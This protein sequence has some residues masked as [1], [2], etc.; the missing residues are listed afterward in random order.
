M[1]G[2]FVRYYVHTYLC[3]SVRPYVRDAVRLGLRFL[4]EVDFG[5]PIVLVT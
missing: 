3:Q 5:V 1:L 2:L 4:L